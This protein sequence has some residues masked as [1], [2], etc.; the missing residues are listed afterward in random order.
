MKDRYQ[1]LFQQLDAR[2]EG[3]FI[4]FIV[5]G[6]PNPERSLAI[7]KTL[8]EAGADALELGLAF[9]D[10]VADGPIIQA[11]DNRALAAGMRQEHA[12]SITSKLREAY[13]DLPMGLLVYANLVEVRGANAFYAAAHEA[14]VDSVL[15][16]DVP[17]LEID[18]YT[19]QAAAHEI[20]LV[21]IATPAADERQLQ[22][23]ARCGR[24]YTYVVTRTGVTGVDED[25]QLCHGELIER[26]EGCGAPPAIFGF[27]IS[28]PDHVRQALAAGAKGA[29][30]GSAVVR[31]IEAHLDDDEALHA[32]LTSFVS[33]MKAA[34]RQPAGGRSERPCH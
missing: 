5:L 17:S 7:A 9:S 21:M 11:A 15:I 6:D 3:A 1:E 20:S 22:A 31:R 4:P 13:P 30:S 26:L 2:R 16:A 34:T 18:G 27:G 10:P 8:V 12:W 24:G 33:K 29:I 32:E 28:K 14:G 25:A 19:A 23:I